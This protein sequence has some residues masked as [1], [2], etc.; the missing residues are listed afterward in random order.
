[1]HLSACSC[2]T[3]CPLDSSLKQLISINLYGLIAVSIQDACPYVMWVG[4]VSPPY[5][6]L[7]AVLGTARLEMWSGF[8]TRHSECW[9]S[10]PFPFIVFVWGK[11]GHVEVR[12]LSTYITISRLTQRRH[13]ERRQGNKKWLYFCQ[14]FRPSHKVMVHCKRCLHCWIWFCLAVDLADSGMLMLLCHCF[15]ECSVFPHNH[16]HVF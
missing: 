7:T 8:Q 11:G 14:T 13:N 2:Y 4:H 9:L 1:M 6:W 10:P 12:N 3:F 15:C 5:P 16:K